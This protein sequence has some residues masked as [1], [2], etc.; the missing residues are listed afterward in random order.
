M[1]N[2]KLFFFLIFLCG[3]DMQFHEESNRLAKKIHRYLVDHGACKYFEHCEN[4]GFV[5]MGGDDVNIITYIIKSE[6]YNQ[7]NISGIINL[8]Y[9]FLNE[10]SSAKSVEIRFYTEGIEFA[11]LLSTA[12]PNL[13]IIMKRE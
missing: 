11:E 9:E 3:C 5:F 12:K 13:V 10:S 6:Y 1:S 4:N 7:K 8:S 2:I